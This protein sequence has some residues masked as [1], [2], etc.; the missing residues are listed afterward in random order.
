MILSRFELEKL[1]RRDLL[2]LANS[3]GIRLDQPESIIINELIE[4]QL[5]LASISSDAEKH[6]QWHKEIMK[7]F[8]VLEEK[9]S[10]LAKENRLLR[11]D[12][13]NLKN[14]FYTELTRLPEIFSEELEKLDKLDIHTLRRISR[15]LGISFSFSSPRTELIALI[16][17]ELKD[18]YKK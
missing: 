13:N 18:K 3:Y 12:L 4:K 5:E 6:A 2:E 17:K 11:E 1:K 15:A 9:I 16:R 10:R 8:Q 14:R 7:Q